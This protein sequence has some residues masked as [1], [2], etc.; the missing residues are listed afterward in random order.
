[1]NIGKAMQAIR[2]EMGFSR[3]EMATALGLTPGALWKVE[4]SKVWPKNAT[5]VKFCRVTRTPLAFLIQGSLA[6]EDYLIPSD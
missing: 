2:E 1:M 3:H 5:I 4:K 6:L